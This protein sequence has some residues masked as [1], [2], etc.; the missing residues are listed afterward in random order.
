MNSALLC[1]S[2]G[3]LVCFFG[4]YKHGAPSGAGERLPHAIL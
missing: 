2:Y 4:Y 1:R 3:A